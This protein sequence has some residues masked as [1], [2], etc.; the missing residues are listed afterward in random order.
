MKI[1]RDIILKWIFF[2]II[3]AFIALSDIAFHEAAVTAG[4]MVGKTLLYVCLLLI[5][6]FLSDRAFSFLTKPNPDRPW[7]R[8]FT[9][10]RKNILRVSAVIFAVYAGFLYIYRPGTCGA[11]TTNQILD[12]VTGM[13]PL[14]FDWW[15]WQGNVSALM[16]DHHPVVTTLIFTAFYKIGLAMGDPNRGLFF[17]SLLQIICLALLFGT[18]VCRMDLYGVPKLF[19]LFSF[20]FFCTPI[21]AF[22]SIAMIKDTL[23]SLVFVFYYLQYTEIIR[24]VLKKEALS[25][26]DLLLLL[27]FSVGIA[28]MNKKGMY[29]ALVSDLALLP[30]FP[31]SREKIRI[32]C[33]A[34]APVFVIIILMRGIL[35][36]LFNIYPGGKQEALGFTFQQTGGLLL[37]DPDAFSEE[38]KAL[39]FRIID[40][41]PEELEIRFYPDRVD[42]LKDHY[43]F[44][45]SDE[46]LAAYRKLWFSQ[47]LRHPLS[48]L[49][50]SLT[51]N[52][53]YFAPLKTANVYAIAE[54]N[55]TLGAFQQ[56][57]SGRA[58]WEA[59]TYRFYSLIQKPIITLFFQ[60]AFIIFWFP[61]ATTFLLLKYCKKT[62]A[63]CMVPLAANMVFLILGPV[64]WTRYGLSHFYTFPV[65]AALPFVFDSRSVSNPDV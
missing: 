10:S 55:E 7:H 52:G 22:F 60:D 29:I 49:R 8:F 13:E 42:G 26:G 65:W 46:D 57:E 45:T 3:S 16:N 6:F 19:A 20:V 33:C 43:N 17:Y 9:Y 64:C 18:I 58:L 15:S 50:I 1:T 31:S 28:L 21:I 54:Y 25:R 63:I 14:P 41:E 36:P 38:D 24:R 56:P 37:E 12:L 44:Y 47:V 61:L 2:V 5:L 40:I 32:L 35:F 62:S 30:L 23:F 34:V 53:G 39:F 59:V 51:V 11:D 27:L 48:A 4:S